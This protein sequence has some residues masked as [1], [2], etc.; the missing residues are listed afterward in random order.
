[1]DLTFIETILHDTVF[2]N[3]T[4]RI[5]DEKATFCIYSAMNHIHA[6]RA[7]QEE[8]IF[9]TLY[10]STAETGDILPPPYGVL[11]IPACSVIKSWHTGSTIVRNSSPCIGRHPKGAYKSAV[12]WM[13]VLVI[14]PGGGCY[15]QWA[16]W[17]TRRA[18]TL[19][20]CIRVVPGP[21]CIS[22]MLG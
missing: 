20:L 16:I 12:W 6:A 15:T 3:T 17:T 8:K 14:T 7:T 5:G 18:P 10:H 11:H 19:L 9:F 21:R 2:R 1:M 4:V 22:P 13:H